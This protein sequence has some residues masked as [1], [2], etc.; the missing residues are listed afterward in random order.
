[1]P[2]SPM[3][4]LLTG[5]SGF[6]AEHILEQL[7]KEGYFV[8]ATVRSEDKRRAVEKLHTG[9]MLEVV[10]VPDVSS[11]GVFANVVK[12]IDYVV[13]TASPFHLSAT[14]M[15]AEM[16]DPAIKGT[17]EILEASAKEE[18]VK[19]VVLTSSMAAVIDTP[20]IPGP[21]GKVYSEK[22][23]NS[24][25]IEQALAHPAFAYHGSKTFA[26][27]A[28]F[29]FMERTKPKF[30][31]VILDM[32]FIYGPMKNQQSLK[33]L[34]TSSAVVYSLISSTPSAGVPPTQVPLWVDVR[35]VARAHVLALKGGPE[36]GNKRFLIHADGTYT[37]GQVVD[38]VKKKFPH[39][40]ERLPT[41]S[42]AKVDGDGEYSSDNAKSKSELGL[43][44][45]YNLEH[46]ITA[47]VED[48]LAMETSTTRE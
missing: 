5:A 45:E 40:A 7:L 16:L 48:L 21:A 25:S 1:M 12:S 3:R 44:Y 17:T 43:A 23:W 14:D 24:V 19:R 8:R 38:I 9:A 34:N 20:S 41:Q 6:L 26:E 2:S 36:I 35:D 10:I 37:F 4:V 47:L 33:S 42:G 30:D 11:P 22:D 15:Q 28:A 46:S 13:H 39:L 27:R 31:I 32:P 18:Q 29:D